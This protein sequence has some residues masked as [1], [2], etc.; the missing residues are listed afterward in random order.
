MQIIFCEDLIG[1]V[2]ILCNA[3]SLSSMYEKLLH[4]FLTSCVMIPKK[5]LYDDAI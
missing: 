3:S 2:L 4:S 5:T 1:P